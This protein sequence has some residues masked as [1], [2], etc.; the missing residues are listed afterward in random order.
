MTLV[1]YIYFRKVVSKNNS[2]FQ[3]IPSKF[4]QES[5][6][7]RYCY[8]YWKRQDIQPRD[9]FTFCCRSKYR[10][11]LVSREIE[12]S[13]RIRT[14]IECDNAEC[15]IDK[16]WS[17]ISNLLINKCLYCSLAWF[18]LA[19]EPV[20]ASYHRWPCNAH[21][22]A[23]RTHRPPAERSDRVVWLFAGIFLVWPTHFPFAPKRAGFCPYR[24]GSGNGL[25]RI[26]FFFN[27]NC[28]A[29]SKPWQI[30]FQNLYSLSN[31]FKKSRF[32]LSGKHGTVVLL[33]VISKDSDCSPSSSPLVLVVGPAPSSR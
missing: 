33:C 17:F 27:E 23:H 32:K 4:L 22:N 15:D 10:S 30:F 7:C 16:Y 24:R 14:L 1:F 18:P 20:P 3:S 6:A 11:W 5:L 12:L 8:V 21:D 29:F 9:I 26:V 28:P 25:Y 31:A 13:T 2:N 19:S